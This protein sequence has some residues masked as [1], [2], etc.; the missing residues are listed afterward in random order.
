MKARGLSGRSVRDNDAFAGPVEPDRDDPWEAIVSVVGE[1]GHGAG[2]QLLGVGVAK[3]PSQ[4]LRVHHTHLLP[5][6]A[7]LNTGGHPQRQPSWGT[8][9]I[10]EPKRRP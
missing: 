5:G 7:E 3:L 4:L 9:L 2:E 8:G 10:R 1:P 6:R